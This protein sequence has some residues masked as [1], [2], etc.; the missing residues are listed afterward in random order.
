MAAV[1]VMTTNN[2]SSQIAS[3]AINDKIDNIAKNK[4][5]KGY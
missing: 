1:F 4:Y 3:L 5:G 2:V